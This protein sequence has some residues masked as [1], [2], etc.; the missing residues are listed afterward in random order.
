MIYY[1]ELALL[2]SPLSPLTYQSDQQIKIGQKVLVKL[3]KRK[4]LS[5]AVI[6]KKKLI[7][8]PLNVQIFHK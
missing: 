4:L 5:E 3:A 8:Q 2:K 7:N 6:I 1:Y